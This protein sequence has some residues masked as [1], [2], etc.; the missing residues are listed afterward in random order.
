MKVSQLTHRQIKNF[1][2]YL[3]E[4]DRGFWVM[5]YENKHVEVMY[6]CGSSHIFKA[7]MEPNREMVITSCEIPEFVGIKSKNLTTLFNKVWDKKYP[8]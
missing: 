4:F 5:A 1:Q 2:S 6:P 7:T 8:N 3:N